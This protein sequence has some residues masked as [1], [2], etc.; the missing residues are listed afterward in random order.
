ML[1]YLVE[2][3]ELYFTSDWSKVREVFL[4]KYSK[5]FT[6][7]KKKETSVD[8][9]K[10][11]DLRTFVDNKLKSL[12]AYTTLP[13][14]NQV[15]IMLLDLPTEVANLFLVNGKMTSNKK[16][17]L[18]F[19]DTIHD[20]VKKMQP[21]S[22]EEAHTKDPIT[23]MELFRFDPNRIS[24]IHVRPLSGGSGRTVNQLPGMTSSNESENTEVES[25]LMS[26]DSESVGT[27][28]RIRRA[29]AKN[30]VGILNPISEDITVASGSD[31]STSTRSTRSS[32]SR[33]Y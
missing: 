20:V 21:E 12:E 27:L 25:G 8:F 22:D 23:R 19:C 6:A 4:K 14:L 29:R 1:N 5:L 18:A 11:P 2:F 10:E 3:S 7:N 28:K 33:P 13:F 26:S 17:M 32:R 30:T 24:D 16:E 31:A 15:E 9:Q